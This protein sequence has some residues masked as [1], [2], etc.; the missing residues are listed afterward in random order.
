[1][2]QKQVR[3]S[4]VWIIAKP[5][6]T[7]PGKPRDCKSPPSHKNAAAQYKFYWD[8]YDNSHKTV[9]SESSQVTHLGELVP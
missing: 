8:G 9:S 6:I 1:M 4:I 2:L 7:V 5:V 3:I